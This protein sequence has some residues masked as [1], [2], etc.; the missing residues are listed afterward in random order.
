MKTEQMPPPHGFIW[1]EN[2][3]FKCVNCGLVCTIAN[4]PMASQ[5]VCPA[6]TKPRISPKTTAYMIWCMAILSFLSI[7]IE[8]R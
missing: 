4:F 2:E 3:T 1:W 7:L 6:I 8:I 5:N